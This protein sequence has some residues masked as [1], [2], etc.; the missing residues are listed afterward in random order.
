MFHGA[1]RITNNF[2]F[3]NDMFCGLRNWNWTQEAISC[4]GVKLTGTHWA[5][6]QTHTP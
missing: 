3:M 5:A 4:W 2:F 6:E 1:Q